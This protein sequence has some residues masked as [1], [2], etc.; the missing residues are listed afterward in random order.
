M[1]RLSGVCNVVLYNKGL[2]VIINLQ[3]GQ[4]NDPNNLSMD[5]SDKRHWGTGDYVVLVDNDT[6]LDYLIFL[7]KQSYKNQENKD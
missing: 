1:V 6:D 7:I 2:Y 5:Y 4:L 3:H